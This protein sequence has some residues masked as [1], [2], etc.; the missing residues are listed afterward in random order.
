[1]RHAVIIAGGAGKRLWPASRRDKPKQL[2]RLLA[3]KCLLELALERMEGLFP[4]ERTLVITSAAY[5]EQVR[6]CLG[7]LPARNVI[8]EPEG[9]DTANAIG[10]AA[11][12]I[13][14][15]D[16][17]GTMAVFTADHIIRPQDEFQRRVERA[18][19]AA[20]EAPDALVTFGITPTFAHT[21]LGYIHCGEKIGESVRRVL[22]FKEKPDHH[23]ARYYCDSGEHFWNSGMFVWRAQTIRD[24]LERF[25]PASARK[26]AAV[27]DAAREGKSID[28]L[29]KEIYPQLA[30]ISIDY[31]VMERATDVLMVELPCE[32]HDV[33]SWPD[34]GRVV[35]P[36]ADGNAVVAS[37]A[38]LLDSA[39]NVIYAEDDHLLAVVGMDEC[40]IVHTPDATLVC[41]KSD[42]QRLKELVDMIGT[43]FGQGYV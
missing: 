13:A 8:G 38:A 4:A 17:E 25:L 40:V 36:D 28:G 11:E 3:G 18:C 42:A 7:S 27:G 12:V 26:L 37:R 22:G 10:L 23:T 35:K 21:G 41:G 16:P 14:A 2:I 33:G 6:A 9:R 39:D 20:E 24:A 5:C 1:M 34:L 43:R 29:L 32:W 30:S 19:R 31:A 15:Q